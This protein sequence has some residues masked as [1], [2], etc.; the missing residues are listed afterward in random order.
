MLLK[1]LENK[2]ADYCMIERGE[3]WYPKAKLI[4]SKSRDL[5]F[6]IDTMKNSA[7]EAKLNAAVII[8]KLLQYKKDILSLDV[9]TFD[10]FKDELSFV[11]QFITILGAD[12]T[13][14]PAT[15]KN[16]LPNIS[17]HGLMA[18]LQN[19]IKITENKVISFFNNR[20]GCTIMIFNSYSCLIG[21]NSKVFKP[22]DELEITAGI[23][24]FSKAAQ[25]QIII[26]SEAAVLEPDG[27]AL[28]K[29][30]V[31]SKPGIYKIPVSISYFNQMTGYEEVRKVDIEYTVT[32][33]CNDQ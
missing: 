1:E 25:P 30:R 33:P 7:A 17:L 14:Q 31:P 12:T 10:A 19:H 20:V 21:Q 18:S 23:G 15:I 6:Y 5:Y 8:N 2:T 32:K 11:N 22:G 9:E 24:A 29:K 13:T 16:S 26:N 3:I 4:A 27:Y 28:Y